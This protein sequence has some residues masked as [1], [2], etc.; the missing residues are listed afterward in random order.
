MDFLFNAIPEPYR[1]IVFGSFCLIIGAMLT[2]YVRSF[3][4]KLVEKFK[5]KK[6]RWYVAFIRAL[7]K[8]LSY[9]IPIMTLLLLAIFL[10][11][12]FE[13]STLG[14]VFTVGQK[15]F[16]VF[17]IVWFLFSLVNEGE[18]IFR[19]VTGEKHRDETTIKA[20]S[21]L[22]RIFLVLLA[23]ILF[24]QTLGIP[25][26][27]VLAFGGIGGIALGF[28]AKDSLSNFFGG[29]MIFLDRP[30]A[31]GDWI[32]SPH[33]EIE[34][35]VEDIGWRL[36]KLRTFEK[37]PLYVPNS[38]FLSTAIE[39]PS[40]M[41]HRRIR[42]TIGLRYQDAKVIPAIIED[43]EA[44]FKKDP[45]IDEEMI[46]FV[47]LSEFA[48][49]SLNLLVYCYTRAT[50]LVDFQIVQGDVFMF[51]LKVIEKHGAQTANHTL[52]VYSGS[53]AETPLM[54]EGEALK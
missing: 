6:K 52:T 49:S 18:K 44:F 37:R 23:G 2:F 47:R 3:F 32:R 14:T 34:G 15:V 21:L 42:T 50:Q 43:I 26:S 30:F 24:L 46:N 4:N 17:V 19:A 9:F 1:S 8:P 39:N 53:L 40:R 35:I 45:R 51:I 36:I 5:G 7:H 13:Y 54:F 38:Y 25:I 31:I 11:H 41:T 48:E 12:R 27:G 10:S 16:V 29:L 33:G 28:A 20:I 22:L